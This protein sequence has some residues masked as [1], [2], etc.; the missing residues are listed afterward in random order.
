MIILTET[1]LEEDDDENMYA[2]PGYDDNCNKRGRGKGMTS[3]FKEKDF[4]HELNINHDGF[5][6]SKITSSDLDIIG[7]YRSQN[8]NVMEIVTELQ[9]LVNK[10]KTTVIGGDF[11]LCVLKH[12]KNYITASLEEEGF[13]QLVRAATHIEGGAID[14]IYINYGAKNKFEWDLEYFPK[15]YSDHDGLGLTIWKSSVHE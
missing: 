11:N 6:L 9:N 14:H 7:V 10:E 12:P 4:K 5:S 3:Y 8:G 15:Y 2:L 13:Q 1:W